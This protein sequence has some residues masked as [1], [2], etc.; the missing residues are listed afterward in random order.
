MQSFSPTEICGSNSFHVGP[1]DSATCGG[2]VR[3]V[4]LSLVESLDFAKPRLFL[5]SQ[6][7]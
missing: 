3:D 4:R 6:S 1:H 7:W 2:E 5:S